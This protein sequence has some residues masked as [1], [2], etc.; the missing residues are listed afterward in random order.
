MEKNRGD[1]KVYI[2]KAYCPGFG[3]PYLIVSA[4]SKRDVAYEEIIADL[5]IVFTENV[6]HIHQL[7][8][9]KKIFDE[10]NGITK[11]SMM[12]FAYEQ[13]V[14]LLDRAVYEKTKAYQYKPEFIELEENKKALLRLYLK[15]KINNEQDDIKKIMD[16][17]HCIELTS[18]LRDIM[19][20]RIEIAIS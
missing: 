13:G 14:N 18:F 16:E 19:A 4:I 6:P 5:F 1:F 10:S 12:E 7:L 17:A 2:S 3:T 15:K 9:T 8:S 20:L 11:E